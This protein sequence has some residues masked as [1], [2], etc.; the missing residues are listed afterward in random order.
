[1]PTTM[2]MMLGIFVTVLGNTR[3]RTYITVVE[4]Q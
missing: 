4:N 3:L 1:M 2:N